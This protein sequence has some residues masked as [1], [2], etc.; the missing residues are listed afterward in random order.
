MTHPAAVAQQHDT[1]KAARI[2]AA[3]EDLVL[4]R[5]FKGITIAEVATKAHV[6]K[7]TVY[8]YWRT[9]ESLFLE[10]VV[11]SFC[12]TLDE[13]GDQLRDRPELS[14]P[15]QLCPHLVHAML[16]RP[17]VRA[18][19]THD[20][21]VL[22]ALTDDPRSRD[23]VRDHGAA[24]LIRSLLPIWRGHGLARLDWTVD[25]QAYA[26]EMLAVGFLQTTTAGR[27][28]ARLDASAR[29][30]TVVAAIDSVLRPAEPS[31]PVTP[32]AVA[33]DV[34]DVLRRATDDLRSSI[35]ESG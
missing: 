9:K 4:K 10:L 27:A 28:V 34:I 17:L 1:G 32:E 16:E 23:L 5:G 3:A 31:G 19:Q 18:L 15:E 26:L 12:I 13:L 6:G 24:A 20:A 2:L 14:R 33:T 29:H 25:Q 30:D 11:R 22:G 21:E 8:L 35:D 7:G